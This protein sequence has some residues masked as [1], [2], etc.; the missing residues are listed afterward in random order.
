MSFK[1][2]IK[3]DKQDMGIDKHQEFEYL[4]QHVLDTSLTNEEYDRR[5]A[6]LAEKLGV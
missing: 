4:R 3:K 2:D 6:A 5:V 1:D